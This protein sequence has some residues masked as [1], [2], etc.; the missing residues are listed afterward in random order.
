[1]KMGICWGCLDAPVKIV[2]IAPI[3]SCAIV[4][5]W[6]WTWGFQKNILKSINNIFN[7]N[8]EK[9]MTKKE[10]KEEQIWRLNPK[11]NLQILNVSHIR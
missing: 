4:V 9:K 10:I 5:P 7:V 11:E 1:M 8:K 6:I 2:E 3:M